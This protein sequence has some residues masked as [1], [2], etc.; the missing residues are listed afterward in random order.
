MDTMVTD[1]RDEPQ[2]DFIYCCGAATELLRFGPCQLHSGH[3]VLFFIVPG[4]LDD[5]SAFHNAEHSSNI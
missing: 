4:E 5:C 2:T 3:K 1:R